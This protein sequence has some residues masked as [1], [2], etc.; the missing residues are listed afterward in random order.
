M[1]YKYKKQGTTKQRRK[2]VRG[3]KIR[4]KFFQQVRN[5]ET[6]QHIRKRPIQRIK[7]GR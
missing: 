2:R 3:H 5:D 1:S 4:N 6:K 7:N